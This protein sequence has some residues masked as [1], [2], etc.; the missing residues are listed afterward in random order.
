VIANLAAIESEDRHA[1]P[2]H[3]VFMFAAGQHAEHLPAMIA[4]KA[5]FAADAVSFFDLREDIGGVI[6]EC[7]RH[8][9]DIAAGGVVAAYAPLGN[10]NFNQI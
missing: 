5:H 6:A 2:P 9:I 7:C 8:P 10:W 3:I 1:G 4:V